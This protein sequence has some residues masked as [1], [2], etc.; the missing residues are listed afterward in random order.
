MTANGDAG[1]AGGSAALAALAGFSPFAAFSA[2]GLAARFGF[3]S[4]AS[5]V[6]STPVPLVALTAV[7]ADF[8][9]EA[10]RRAG[11]AGD[12]SFA[13]GFSE[14][15]AISGSS[16]GWAAALPAGYSRA[17]VRVRGPR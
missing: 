15:L 7:E 13:G 4:A 10:R 5:G 11:F 2:F 14:S 3:A 17:A 16:S 6:S 9:A 1:A 12:S 8:G